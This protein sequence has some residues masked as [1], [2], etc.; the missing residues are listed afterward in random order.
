MRCQICDFCDTTNSSPTNNR[1]LLV[2]GQEVCQ[3]CYEESMNALG[4]MEF[5]D[6]NEQFTCGGAE[7]V[8]PELPIK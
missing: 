4:E 6:D 8:L 7:P 1:V 3:D 2:R 5:D